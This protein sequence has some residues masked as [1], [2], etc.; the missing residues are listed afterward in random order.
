M[1]KYGKTGRKTTTD[2]MRKVATRELKKAIS[3]A[4]KDSRSMKNGRKR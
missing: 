3:R 4:V 1:P 2:K